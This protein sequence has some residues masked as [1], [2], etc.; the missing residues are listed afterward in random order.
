[1]FPDVPTWMLVAAIAVLLAGSTA[2]FLWALKDTSK[3]MDDIRKMLREELSVKDVQIAKLKEVASELPQTSF[4][5]GHSYAE[6]PQGARVV[7]M[8]DGT[9]RLVL[10]ARISSSLKAGVPTVT[11][12][13]LAVKAPD[14]D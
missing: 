4:E 1:M 14:D 2:F 6:L 7:T 5:N 10:P 11:V 9:I 12:S 13:G 8:S 3:G